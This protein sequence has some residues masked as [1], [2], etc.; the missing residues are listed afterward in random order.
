MKKE[1][2]TVNSITSEKLQAQVSTAIIEE[3]NL[4]TENKIGLNYY[5]QSDIYTQDELDEQYKKIRLKLDLRLLPII[6]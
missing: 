2:S 3:D 4:D 6:N 1:D 5:L